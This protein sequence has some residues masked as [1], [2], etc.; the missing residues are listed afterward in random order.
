MSNCKIAASKQ[1]NIMKL[2]Y[3]TSSTPTPTPTS[4]QLQE[5]MHTENLQG[6]Q[7]RY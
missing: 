3:V 5:Q 6:Q 4:A 7:E 1:R 2:Q